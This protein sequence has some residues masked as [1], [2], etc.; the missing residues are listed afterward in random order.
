MVGAVR[1]RMS[2]DVAELLRL[3]KSWEGKFLSTCGKRGKVFKRR[4]Q[5]I[6][7]DMWKEF[8]SRKTIPPLKFCIILLNFTVI[9]KT[10]DLQVRFFPGSSPY[11]YSQEEGKEEEREE[12]ME[13]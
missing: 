9:H 10:T 4:K 12:V 8:K 5:R 13:E 11:P 1:L 3:N 7:F 2:I 6:L